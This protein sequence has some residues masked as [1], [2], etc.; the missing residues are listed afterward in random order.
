MSNAQSIGIKE[1]SQLVRLANGKVAGRVEN[2]A[3]VKPVRGSKHMLRTPRAWAV[4]AEAYDSIRRDIN[5]IVVEDEESGIS[6]R[7]TPEVFDA[8][9]GTLDRGFGRQYFLPLARWQI[10][11]EGERQLSLNLV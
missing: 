10:E 5:L 6:Y 7:A 1:H 11:R 4:D 3:F 8:F 9:R 2:G